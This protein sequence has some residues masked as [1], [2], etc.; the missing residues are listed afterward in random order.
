M[1]AVSAAFDF[2]HAQN[3]TSFTSGQSM[4]MPATRSGTTYTVE[5]AC[6]PAPLTAR[7]ATAA[8]LVTTPNDGIAIHATAADF[9]FT[10]RPD[11][12][13]ILGATAGTGTKYRILT[14]TG[15]TGVHGHYRIVAE[16]H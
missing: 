13:F 14:A 16:R 10:P 15:A 8:G 6:V 9:P 3:K 1:S 5:V 7:A 11:D 4:W 12:L 2:L